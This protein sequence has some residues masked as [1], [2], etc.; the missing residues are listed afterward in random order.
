MNIQESSDDLVIILTT[1]INSVIGDSLA[2]EILKLKLAACVSIRDVKSYFFWEGKLEKT[3]E[4]QLLIKTREELLDEL[5]KTINQLHS[6]KNPEILHWKVS[7]SS[8]YKEW[9]EAVT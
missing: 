4:A 6:Y 5:I 3:N 2:E 1:E 7:A 8:C 9:V